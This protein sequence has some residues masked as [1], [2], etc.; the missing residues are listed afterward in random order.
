[1]ILV[2]DS[3]STKADWQVVQNGQLADLYSTMGFS[4]FYHTS[5]FIAGH[6]ATSDLVKLPAREVTHI[7]YYGTGIHD[8]NRAEIIRAGLQPLF[9]TA[10]IHVVHDLLGAARATCG[11]SPGVACILGTGSNSCYYNGQQIVDN[12][13]S[14]GFLL[15]DEA[16]GAH[17]GKALLKSFFYRE[18]A[19]ELKE[20]FDTMYPEGGT[21]IKDRVYAG[22]ANVYV[23]SFTYFLYEHRQH[24]QIKRIILNCFEEFVRRQ[25]A[26]YEK[27]REVRVHFVGSIA[28]HFQDILRE[29]LSNYGL[30]LGEIV[31]KPI[32]KLA[33]Y[34][35]PETVTV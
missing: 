27:A 3:G 22:N 21:A 1:M 17:L 24:P 30:K 13:P 26:K 20:A 33:Q 16:S 23:A 19:P 9:P 6:L 31:R 4:P 34:H 29:S 5:A 11:R 35:L 2:V 25:V 8:E 15:G 14:L 28:W 12:V 7:H 18:L 32:L 10:S